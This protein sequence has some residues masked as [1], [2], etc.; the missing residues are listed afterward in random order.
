MSEAETIPAPSDLS[1]EQAAVRASELRAEIRRHSELYYNGEPEIS[2]AEFDALE[3]ELREL[4]DAFP[5]LRQDSPLQEGSLTESRT[6]SAERGMNSEEPRRM[7]M[8]P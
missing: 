3:A 6:P 8:P 1:A 4:Q 5:E 7:V 2:D